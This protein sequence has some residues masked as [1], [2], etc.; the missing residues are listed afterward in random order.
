MKMS[1]T[2]QVTRS[3]QLDTRRPRSI[4]SIRREV[5][6]DVELIESPFQVLEGGEDRQL[7]FAATPKQDII[8]DS[9]SRSGKL[10]FQDEESINRY[11]Y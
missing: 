7:Y 3:E 5:R 9:D 10:Y 11:S 8:Y 4:E 2:R 6:D 1:R